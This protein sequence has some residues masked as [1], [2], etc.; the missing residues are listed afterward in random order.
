MYMSLLSSAGLATANL[1]FKSPDIWRVISTKRLLTRTFSLA[2]GLRYLREAPT[3]TTLQYSSRNLSTYLSLTY[4]RYYQAFLGILSLGIS[5]VCEIGA[6]VMHAQCHCK[7]AM[8]L[9]NFNLLDVNLGFRTTQI[10]QRDP[11]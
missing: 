3:S 9:E 6:C 4:L 7:S 11:Q 5:R 2:T 8:S 10:A 1:I